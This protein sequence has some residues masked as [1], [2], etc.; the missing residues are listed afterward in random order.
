MK[1]IK[2]VNA[3]FALALLVIPVLLISCN[4]EGIK[5]SPGNY[6]IQ[7][8]QDLEPSFSPDG[9]FIAYRH[10]GDLNNTP[11]SPGSYQ[12]GLYIINKDGSNRKLVLLGTRL[13]PAWSPEGK[14][15]VFST[16]GIIQKCGTNGDSLKTFTCL[17]N[18]SYPEFYYPKWSS[19]GKL[20][21]F[22]K[23]LGSDWGFY[24]TATNFLGSGRFLGLEILGRNPEL[25]PSRN[26][27]IYEAGK[28]GGTNVSVSE[29]F[30]LNINGI[31]KIQ[32]T[33]NGRVNRAPTWS[34]D[35]TMIAWSGNL[36][37]SMMN[38][39]GT[40]QKDIEYGNSP[41]WSANNEIVY[42]HANSDYTKEVLYTISPD[43]KN[44]KQITF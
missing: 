28:G 44:K 16:S 34:P 20:I 17:N 27:L 10:D 30:L 39:D 26:H 40:A 33:I 8:S 31:T 14:W 18:L 24:T 15:L 5:P 9:N 41:S 7:G 35:G 11:T 29:I 6:I 37:L 19:D 22:D 42:S 3:L 21:L 12:S 43:G 2:I 36:H 13:N 32:L 38:A 23:P 25:S 4:T 1:I